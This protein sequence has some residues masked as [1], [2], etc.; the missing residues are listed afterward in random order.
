M[1]FV[2]FQG[3]TGHKIANLDPNWAFPNCNSSLNS[4]MALKWYRKLDEVQKSCPIV[5]E[6]IH[7]ISRSH[8]L[9]SR[10]FESNFGKIT[11]LVAAIKPLKFLPCHII[12]WQFGFGRIAG[13]GGK[14]SIAADLLM[15]H[16]PG[17]KK[18]MCYNVG[19]RLSPHC[20]WQT[21][22][23]FMGNPTN[24]LCENNLTIKLQIRFGD[25][26]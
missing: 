25:S 10:R 5:F 8:R 1:P 7:Q 20:P 26:L 15:L 21:L 18:L 2:K 14:F 12:K 16:L 19:E 6:V 11:R 23:P 17:V 4:P 22:P 3:R 24:H 13:N 9:K